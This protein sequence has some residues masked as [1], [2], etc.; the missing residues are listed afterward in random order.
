MK[1]KTQIYTKYYKSRLALITVLILFFF[2]HWTTTDDP[3]TCVLIKDAS[4]TTTTSSSMP[5]TLGSQVPAWRR[6]SGPGHMITARDSN[7]SPPRQQQAAAAAAL[8]L[9]PATLTSVCVTTSTVRRNLI[10]EQNSLKIAVVVLITLDSVWL[11]CKGGGG[12]WD[13]PQ[14]SLPF[15]LYC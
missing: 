1:S 9:K 2:A 10:I 7:P 3:Y 11:V 5:R 6:G 4:S 12:W 15:G 14:N 13:D 8:P